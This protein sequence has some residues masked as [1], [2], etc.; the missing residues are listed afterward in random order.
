MLGM[1]HQCFIGGCNSEPSIRELALVQLFQQISIWTTGIPAPSWKGNTTIGDIDLLWMCPIPRLSD[2]LLIVR[3]KQRWSKKKWRISHCGAVPSPLFPPLSKG[4]RATEL[5]AYNTS[6]L[7]L[8]S[9]H[10]FHAALR[11]FPN[12]LSALRRDKPILPK[13]GCHA[14]KPFTALKNPLWLLHKHGDSKGHFA[15]A[16]LLF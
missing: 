8:C 16:H 3:L 13:H 5:R 12:I 1:C 9:S 14:Y 7:R 10:H 11:W 6:E 4:W 2:M 15:Q